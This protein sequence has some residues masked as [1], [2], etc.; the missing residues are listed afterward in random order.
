MPEIE[1][2]S[3][4]GPVVTLAARRVRPKH[5]KARTTPAGDMHL[6]CFMTYLGPT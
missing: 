4:W 1:K 5:T 6:T 2:C 3:P